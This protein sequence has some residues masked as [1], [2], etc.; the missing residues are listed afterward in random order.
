[1]LLAYAKICSLQEFYTVSSD[2]E[3]EPDVRNVGAGQKAIAP[4]GPSNEIK[5]HDGKQQPTQ[6]KKGAGAR[7]SKAAHLSIGLGSVKQGASGAAADAALTGEIPLLLP[8]KLSNAKVS[9][10]FPELLCFSQPPL[11]KPI[12]GQNE[13]CTMGSV[14]VP[15]Q[16]C[17]QAFPVVGSIA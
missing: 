1:M 2:E 16:Y 9:N 17:L 3:D 8:A 15:S 5:G 7:G 12:V 4:K 6:N 11:P 14:G 10:L 13:A